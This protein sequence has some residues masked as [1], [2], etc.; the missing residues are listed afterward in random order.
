MVIVSAIADIF[1]PIVSSLERIYKEGYELIYKMAIKPNSNRDEIDNVDKMLHLF[2]LLKQKKTRLTFYDNGDISKG[3]D[4][5]VQL[6]L[7]LQYAIDRYAIPDGVIIGFILGGSQ[8][9][10][11]YIIHN[12][13][14]ELSCGNVFLDNYISLHNKLVKE[15]FSNIVIIM[16]KYSR[17]SLLVYK[18]ISN[19]IHYGMAGKMVNKVIN[20]IYQP[21]QEILRS[22]DDEINANIE[23][24]ENAILSA[25]RKK[26]IHSLQ[27]A[28]M[29]TLTDFNIRKY[30]FK[31][32]LL[33]K[34]CYTSLNETQK[35]AFV[36]NLSMLFT[37]KL[38]PYKLY[39][40]HSNE[41]IFP[42]F[43]ID[44]EKVKEIEHKYQLIYDIH[45]YLKMK[46]SFDNLRININRIAMHMAFKAPV[47]AY[48]FYIVRHLCRYFYINIDNIKSSR[49]DIVFLLPFISI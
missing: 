42:E 10:F 7:F 1:Y 32:R 49:Q 38:L 17:D 11:T 48:L 36:I 24:I 28:S 35:K 40:T 34:V 8:L 5:L 12:K 9:L 4:S 26:M 37:H 25:R 14:S 20:D 46:Y 15:T 47:S 6:P 16:E 3:H 22:K 43:I 39:I 27:M 13:D 18:G 2:H 33:S 44:E 41:P 30:A 31:G 23:R 45:H 29:H 19:V 21:L